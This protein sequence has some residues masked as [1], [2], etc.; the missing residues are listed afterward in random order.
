MEALAVFSIEGARVFID[1]K[2]KHNKFIKTPAINN[3]YRTG[4]LFRERDGRICLLASKE[5][6][7]TQGERVTMNFVFACELV[8][9]GKT[10]ALNPNSIKE[11]IKVIEERRAKNGAREDENADIPTE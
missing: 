9:E 10:Y 5:T 8:F 11:L 7:G 6:E 3:K 2:K 4:G 1:V